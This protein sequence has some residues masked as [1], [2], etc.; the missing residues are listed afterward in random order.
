MTNAHVYKHKDAAS[1]ISRNNTGSTRELQGHY[2]VNSKRVDEM[3]SNKITENRQTDMIHYK[4]YV[5]ENS[6]MGG[7]IL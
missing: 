4:I 1:S 7:A 2:S 5:T 6:K 3:H